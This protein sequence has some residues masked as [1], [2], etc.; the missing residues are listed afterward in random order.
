MMAKALVPP[1]HY[2]R[3]RRNCHNCHYLGILVSRVFVCRRENGPEFHR[4]HP[5]E[6]VCDRWKKRD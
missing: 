6:F 5:A 2:R 3:I 1:K 4:E